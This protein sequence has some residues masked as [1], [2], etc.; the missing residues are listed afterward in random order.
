MCR[1]LHEAEV[2]EVVMADDLHLEKKYFRHTYIYK[3]NDRSIIIYN[4]N[5]T[6]ILFLEIVHRNISIFGHGNK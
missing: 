1:G 6:Y 3:I 4:A 2:V 5:Y